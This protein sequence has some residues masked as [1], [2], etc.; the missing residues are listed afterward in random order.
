MLCREYYLSIHLVKPLE[1][2]RTERF[3]QATTA[4]VQKA[5]NLHDVE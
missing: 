3:L 1:S 2:M 4:P 5:I